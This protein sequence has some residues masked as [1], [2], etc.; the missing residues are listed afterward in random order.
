M[1]GS[2][3]ESSVEGS[4]DLETPIH[5]PKGNGTMVVSGKKQ[6]GTWNLTDLTLQQNGLDM[7][8]LPAVSSSNCQ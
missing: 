6:D 4:A 8:L 2:L 5:G 3:T 7:E 1:T